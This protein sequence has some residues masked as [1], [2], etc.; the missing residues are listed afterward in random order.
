MQFNDEVIGGP[1]GCDSSDAVHGYVLNV[2]EGLEQQAVGLVEV[3]IED[4][5][6]ERDTEKD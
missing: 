6:I 2:G 4:R 3:G 5:Y 1:P